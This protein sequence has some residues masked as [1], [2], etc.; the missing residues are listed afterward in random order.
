MCYEL[1]I[2]TDYP[3]DLSKF[4]TVGVYFEKIDT[5]KTLK[6]PYHYRVATIYPKNCSCHLRIYDQT[7]LNRDL[8]YNPNAMQEWYNEKTD[9]DIVL[10]T[11]FLFQIIKNLVNQGHCFV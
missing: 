3:D 2:S 1:I 6:Y 4:D 7:T 11:R 9:D 10:N 5:R 8:A